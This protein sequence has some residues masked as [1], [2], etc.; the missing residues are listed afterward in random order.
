MYYST[1]FHESQ[2]FQRFDFRDS[3]ESILCTKVHKFAADAY[4]NSHVI[5]SIVSDSRPCES[6]PLA[7]SQKKSEGTALSPPKKSATANET[8]KALVFL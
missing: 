8:M 6:H 4:S 1:A 2:V 7:M 5:K 3:N